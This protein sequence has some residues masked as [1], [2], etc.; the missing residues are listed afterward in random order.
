MKK[1]K[2]GFVYF[3]ENQRKRVKKL[4]S[5]IF[6]KKTGFVYLFRGGLGEKNWVR[7]FQ[8][9][10][11][12]AQPLKAY[13]KVINDVYNFKVGQES[14]SSSSNSA[15]APAPIPPAPPAPT[16]PADVP[17]PPAGGN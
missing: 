12:I 8:A 1:K 10:G 14:A 5:F 3:L 2:T 6:V 7:L 9:F 13:S 11:G 17:M 15:K 4:D 16:A